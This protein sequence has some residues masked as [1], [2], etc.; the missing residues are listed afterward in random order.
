VVSV[1]KAR[2]VKGTKAAKI[3][4][5]RGRVLPK[6]IHVKYEWGHDDPWL[7]ANEDVQELA[8]KGETVYV[9]E[10][11]LVKVRK[12]SLDLRVA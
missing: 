11:R 6:T 2:D 1:V 12:I 3:I 9:G 5:Q 7:E 4:E 8:E 10:Y